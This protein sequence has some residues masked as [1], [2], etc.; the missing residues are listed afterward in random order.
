MNNIRDH[1]AAGLIAAVV[2][3]IIAG[4]VIWK[5][6]ATQRDFIA[7][8]FAAQDTKLQAVNAA[9]AKTADDLKR[10]NG[11]LQT[12]EATLRDVKDQVSLVGTRSGMEKLNTL[13]EAANK[14]L[15]DIKQATGAGRTEAALAPLAGKLDALGKAVA[16]L[17]SKTDDKA[18]D[19]SRDQAL[20]G[21]RT[22]IAGVKAAIAKQ[23][24]DPA[25][26]QANA[27][28]DD[29]LRAL[30]ALGNT[31]DGLKTGVDANAAKLADASKSLNALK[32]SVS[33]NASKL[34][35]TATSLTALDT[36]VKQGFADTAAKQADLAKAV[37]KPAPAAPS[38][39]PAKPQQDLVVFYVTMAGKAAATP[40]PAPAAQGL[41]PTVPPPLAVHYEKIGG[42]NDDGQAKVIAD[43]LRAIMKGHSGCTVAVAGHAD[44]LGSDRANY[45]L[46]K[47]RATAVADKLKAAFAGEPVT[48]T[49]TQWGERRLT[50][51]TPDD[52]AN[53]ANRRVDIKV[54]CGK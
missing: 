46:S 3:G 44:T 9:L 40:A 25:L 33:A 24:T 15:A 31:T 18:R 11:A 45:D 20:A 13:V 5:I 2:T 54:S 43:R 34:N 47:Q 17:P 42:I 27:K 32:D 36:A 38:A 1:L 14:N 4:A 39:P 51:W 26:T 7:T 6:T 19:Q 49:Q 10:L 28:L 37:A 16:A 8:Q 30:V 48:I 52:T 50:Q 12:T 21:I 23:P 22:A 41:T 53:E 35:R 29:A